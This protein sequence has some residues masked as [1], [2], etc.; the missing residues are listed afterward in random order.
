MVITQGIPNWMRKLVQNG[1]N[2]YPTTS[3]TDVVPQSEKERLLVKRDSRKSSV[4][5]TS[6][7]QSFN[8]RAMSFKLLVAFVLLILSRVGWSAPRLY[9]EYQSIHHKTHP[10]HKLQLNLRATQIFSMSELR[11]SLLDWKVAPGR[12]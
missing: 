12:V 9:S 1:N 5:Q 6:I 7:V 11:N 3:G 2:I 8:W 4:E 10:T